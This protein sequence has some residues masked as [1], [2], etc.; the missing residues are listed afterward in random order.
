MTTPLL[1]RFS[2]SR[3]V[4][5]QPWEQHP[6]SRVDLDLHTDDCAACQRTTLAIYDD[7]LQ[8]DLFEPRCETGAL[9]AERLCSLSTAWRGWR[10][11]GA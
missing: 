11:S 8:R 5:L 7:A 6:G 3:Q 4:L 2:V 9:L 10:G 1:V